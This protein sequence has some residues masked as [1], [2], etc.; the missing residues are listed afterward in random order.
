MTVIRHNVV[1]LLLCTIF[2]MK[3]TTLSYLCIYRSEIK[4]KLA[5]RNGSLEHTTMVVCLRLHNS[6]GV[7]CA[8]VVGTRCN[9]TSS[10]SRAVAQQNVAFALEYSEM[11][12]IALDRHFHRRGRQAWRI[13][14]L[15]WSCT[16]CRIS[17]LDEPALCDLNF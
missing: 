1:M 11:C 3:I 12:R 5:A 2:L 7:E 4:R 17:R 10:V 16:G 9:T 13:L 14:R 8:R 6:F 15:N